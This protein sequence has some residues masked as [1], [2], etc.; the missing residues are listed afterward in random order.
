MEHIYEKLK[1]LINEYNSSPETKDSI[2][3]RTNATLA[4]YSSFKIGGP[5]DIALFPKNERA[6]IFLLDN[7]ASK[8]I[9]FYVIGN[10]SNVLFD[11]EG[12]RGAVIFTTE[13]KEISVTSN[14]IF[15]EC[16][17]GITKI[18]RVALEHSLTGLE[19]ACGIPGSLGGAVYMNAGAYGGEMSDVVI[20]SR[21]YDVKKKEIITVRG[22]EHGYGYRK[23][24][25]I[26]NGD[27]VILSAKLELKNASYD[28]MRIGKLKIR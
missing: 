1:D 8:G 28:E 14:T 12:I 9:E 27:M 4:E 23:S 10:G 6:A 15:A 25:Y 19:F 18:S 13:M 7:L 24:I 26:G 21:Y 20:E 11:D 16:G 3:Y 2:E 22:E 5:C 17:A